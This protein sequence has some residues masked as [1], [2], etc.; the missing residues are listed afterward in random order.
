MTEINLLDLYP[1]TKRPI[2]ERAKTVTSVDREIARQFG[3]EFFDGDRRQGYGGYRYD[4]RWNPVVKRI[5]GYYGLT[6]RDAVLDVGCAKGFTLHDFREVLPGMKVAGVDISSYA[7]SCAMDSVRPYL[8][9]A[10]ASHLPF[11][12]KSF[13]FVF[14]INTIHNLPESSCRQALREIERVS[15]RHKF[16]VVDAYRS[17]GEKERMEQWNL[18]A[19]TYFE[20]E[21][22]KRFFKEAGYTGDYYWFIAE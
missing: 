18:T 15:R 14:S 10:N 4:G 20:T 12:D 9:V 19:L 11:P 21:R 8:T 17:P 3:K 22:W 6:N 13:D 2:A 5:A 7:I 16:V 1:R